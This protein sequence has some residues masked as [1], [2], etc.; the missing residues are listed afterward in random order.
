MKLIVQDI[1]STIARVIGV[2]VDDARVYDYIKEN[3]NIRNKYA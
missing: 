1:R 3:S 2:C